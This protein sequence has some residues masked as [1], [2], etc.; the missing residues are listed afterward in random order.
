MIEEE[1]EEGTC[2]RT[3]HLLWPLRNFWTLTKHKRQVSDGARQRK[4]SPTLVRM[5]LTKTSFAVGLARVLSLDTMWFNRS[6]FEEI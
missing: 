3:P 4:R 1:E 5:K 2:P 6:I